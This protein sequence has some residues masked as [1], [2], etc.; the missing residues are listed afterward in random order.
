MV[1][2]KNWQ[3]TIGMGSRDYLSLNKHSFLAHY[4]QNLFVINSVERQM[5]RSVRTVT[6]SPFTEVKVYCFV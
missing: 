4:H 2:V 1:E 3:I 6:L 5:D